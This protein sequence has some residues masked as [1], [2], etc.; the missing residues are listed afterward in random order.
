MNSTEYA[1]EFFAGDIYAT[2]TT[3]IKIEL[4]EKDHAIC[5]LEP[6]RAHLNA[7]GKVMGGALFTLADF[8][9]AVASNTDN[10]PTVTLASRIS[11]IA[12]ADGGKLFAEA[13]CLRSGKTAAMFLIEIKDISG[14]LIACVS[15]T[16]ARRS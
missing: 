1:R 6:S 9:F 14:R 3:G 8:A 10:A 5:S 4:A 11:Y 16:G 15:V 12:P 2:E 7:N 13:K